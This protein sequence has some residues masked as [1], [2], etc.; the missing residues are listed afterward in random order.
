MEL[1]FHL[2][3]L[4]VSTLL[5]ATL[6][7][8]VSY[9]KYGVAKTSFSMLAT[10]V[11]LYSGGYTFQLLVPDLCWHLF[12]VRIQYLG[13]VAMPL[14]LLWFILVMTGNERWLNRVSI[15]L[16]SL[17]SL[18][19]MALV[20]CIEQHDLFYR[21]TTLFSQGSLVTLSFKAGVVYYIW[22]VYQNLL[23]LASILILLFSIVKSSRKERSLLLLIFVGL[24]P[25]LIAHI[26]YLTTS[27]PYNID[28][29]PFLFSLSAIVFFMCLNKYSIFNVAPVAKAR[30]FD[31]MEDMTIAI[32]AEKK[33][34]CLNLKAKKNFSVS[35]SIIGK[36]FDQMFANA[37]QS[38]DPK[39]FSISA[40]DI[41]KILLK[42][43]EAIEVMV[44]G[45]LEKDSARTI[46]AEQLDDKKLSAQRFF[47]FSISAIIDEELHFP[48]M[49]KKT[50]TNPA[51][52]QKRES[53][54]GLLLSF[55][56][57]TELKR[58]EDMII[59]LAK[60]ME[61]IR[62]GVVITDR[63]GNIV[64]VNPSLE[65]IT[66]YTKEE[67][68]GQNPRI[69]K[70]GEHD[71]V[72]YENLWSSLTSGMVWVG[73]IV[74]RKK[75]GELYTEETS[76]TPIFNENRGITNYIAVKKD[77]SDRQ[78]F[79]DEIDKFISAVEQ[80]G[81]VLIIFNSEGEVEYVNSSFEKISG[82]SRE[83]IIGKSF[84][85]IR[86]DSSQPNLMDDI[87]NELSR[88]KGWYGTYTNKTKSGVDYLIE[89]KIRPVFSRSGDVSNYV[90]VEQDITDRVK[91]EEKL[92][93]SE[94]KYRAIAETTFVG[95][96]M[97]D[98]DFQVTYVN[99]ALATMMGYSREEIMGR[100]LKEI[101]SDDLYSKISQDPVIG[102]LVKGKSFESSLTTRN[103]DTINVLV[104]LSPLLSAK[105]DL[106]GYIAI[107]LDVTEKQ[108]AIESIQETARER[109]NFVSMVSHE[110]KIPLTVI[111]EG[112]S[113]VVDGIAG[114]VNSD[115]R[116]LLENV[117]S[118]VS[119]LSRLINEVLEFQK[120]E[121]GKVRYNFVQENINDLII[122]TV[123]SFGP[124]VAKKGLYIRHELDEYLPLV[125]IDPDK[126]V[127]VL[128]NVI[129]NSMKFTEYGGITVSS[130]LLEHKQ[131][132]EISI[133]DTGT[134]IDN[135]V[136]EKVFDG[137]FVVSTKTK[138]QSGG[139]GL[140]L[141]ISKHLIEAH[142]GTI[143]IESE[144]SKG[145]TVVL[146]LPIY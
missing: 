44:A 123:K 12:W 58:T 112:V 18:F 42:V 36:P 96:G 113:L 76:I 132:I 3:P 31:L 78:F 35:N 48:R 117:S 79:Q 136:L 134:G 72:F 47:E 29:T 122:N 97:H 102:S 57:I 103:G 115:Q 22:L 101:L 28:V 99:Q 116:E 93:E 43:D 95:I 46:I 75:S 49:S 40:S 54:L 88:G 144:L 121:S 23:Y 25:P 60:A 143:R 55:H 62:E 4:I 14:L 98:K 74:N 10:A 84:F 85:G 110:L 56:E 59:L 68:I 138:Y 15:I 38:D 13:I 33:I 64:Y 67:L 41:E 106:L 107:I 81:E 80:L 125:S 91:R 104:S 5:S 124:V 70:S 119:R 128:V 145:T 50:D 61:S 21:D 8:W 20:L 86:H 120:L 30:I 11:F 109:S 83:E 131:E 39:R 77:I 140:G 63:D 126:I 108:K 1:E 142:K 26:A 65:F 71:S 135:K 17:P 94:E 141:P 90:V 37:P 52:Q 53:Y 129:G 32:D 139:T 133:S 16:L 73:E 34:I 105:N 92:R 2:I 27:L 24:L 114:E 6:I 118:N 127:Q 89:S 19:V 87:K 146:T 111:K 66:G 9:Q 69:L 100:N 45:D 82:Y 7:I 130:K 51:N 137:F